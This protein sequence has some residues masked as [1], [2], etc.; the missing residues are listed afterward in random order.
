M[1]VEGETLF[2]L[3]A[4]KVSSQGPWDFVILCFGG[5]HRT[6]LCWWKFFCFGRSHV[7]PLLLLGRILVVPVWHGAGGFSWG[8]GGS[9]G[10]GDLQPDTGSN[11]LQ[12]HSPLEAGPTCQGFPPESCT[13]R[14]LPPPP[15]SR[16]HLCPFPPSPPHPRPG[17]HSVGT[18]LAVLSPQEAQKLKGQTEGTLEGGLSSHI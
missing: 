15:L 10:G 18:H 7:S 4:F 13:C 12:G 5:N 8:E 14:P 1:G 11:R 16:S 3:L 17:T 6:C 9:G 2:L